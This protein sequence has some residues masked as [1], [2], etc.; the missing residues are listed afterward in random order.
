MATWM[1]CYAVANFAAVSREA[2]F[3]GWAVCMFVVAGP[4]LTV[5]CAVVIR[6]FTGYSFRLWEWCVYLAA[7]AVCWVL[8]VIIMMWAA[9]ASC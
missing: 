6:L 4:L 3:E 1:A 8:T 5:L 7:A 2:M 9:A